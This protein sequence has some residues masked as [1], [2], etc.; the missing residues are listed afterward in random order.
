ML[1]DIMFNNGKG[2]YGTPL[3]VLVLLS[4]WEVY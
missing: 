2:E 4:S 3:K 1:S